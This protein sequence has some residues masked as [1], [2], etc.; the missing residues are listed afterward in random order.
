MNRLK[1]FR[2]EKKLS[3]AYVA[4]KLGMSKANYSKKENGLVK[5]TIAE[6]KKLSVVLDKPI[7]SI[8]FTK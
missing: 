7:D 5:I 6:A 2:L 4:N 3:Q 8:F 1:E